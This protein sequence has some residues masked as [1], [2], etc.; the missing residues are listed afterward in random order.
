[1]FIPQMLARGDY[2]LFGMVLG[3]GVVYS[4]GVIPFAMKKNVA[5]FIWHLFVL[6]G[7]I[8]QWIGIYVA[9]Y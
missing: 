2:L 4:I 6:A 8:I 5:H 9:I 1:M 3:G 7:A